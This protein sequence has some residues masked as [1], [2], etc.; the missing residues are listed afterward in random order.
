[1]TSKRTTKS[2]LSGVMRAATAVH[3]EGSLVCA[4]SFKLI[5]L[6]AEE[7]GLRKK[8]TRQ[9]IFIRSEEGF[10]ESHLPVT[11]LVGLLCE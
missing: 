1:M 8:H 10:L 9:K 2:L 4:G 6:I 7:D 3:P 5:S 11:F